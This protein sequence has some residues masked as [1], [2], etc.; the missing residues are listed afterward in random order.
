MPNKWEDWSCP[1]DASR[2]DDLYGNSLFHASVE[3]CANPVKSVFS[4]SS[5]VELTV[6]GE[7]YGYNT[8]YAWFHLLFLLMCR[9]YW[10]GNP[11][12]FWV[13]TFDSHKGSVT[14][15][16]KETYESY[17]HR[18]CTIWATAPQKAEHDLLKW[19][20]ASMLKFQQKREF[21]K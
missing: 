15:Y 10:T 14:Q 3:L 5:K 8:T 17:E 13:Q 12:P 16:R 2:G 6:Q 18:R 21:S 11:I 19:R 20:V 1:F 9:S 7:E 4:S